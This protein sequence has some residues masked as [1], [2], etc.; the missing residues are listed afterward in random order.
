MEKAWKILQPTREYKQTKEEIEIIRTAAKN[1][2]KPFATTISATTG[3]ISS[4]RNRED[5]IRANTEN[6]NDDDD[7]MIQDII[8][9]NFIPAQS[10]SHPHDFF[11]RFNANAV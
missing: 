2:E 6:V 4:A 10:T 1:Y 3:K 8:V 7:I 5:E 11:S 9:T